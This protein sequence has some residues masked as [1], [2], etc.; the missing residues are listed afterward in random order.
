M[1]MRVAH[2][3]HILH[4]CISYSLVVETFNPE[5][6]GRKAYF[7]PLEMSFF[8]EEH[9]QNPLKSPV[10]KLFYGYPKFCIIHLF[11]LSLTNHFYHWNYTVAAANNLS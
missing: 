1:F 4:G 11:Q 5:K 7:I 6:N 2:P 8:R 10:G 3:N 9:I